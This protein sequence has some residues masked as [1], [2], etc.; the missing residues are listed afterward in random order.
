MLEHRADVGTVRTGILEA[1]QKEGKINLDDFVV[2][3]PVHHDGWP[4][5]CSTH[6]YPTW[7]LVTLVHTSESVAAALKAALLSLPAGDPGLQNAGAKGFVEPKN[8]EALQDLVD[9]L[10]SA[11]HELAEVR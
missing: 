5:L 3:N 10:R 11:G 2:L 7:P 8:Y 4:L 1:M 6:L 9:Y